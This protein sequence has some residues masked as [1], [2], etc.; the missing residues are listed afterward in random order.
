MVTENFKQLSIGSNETIPDKVNACN[1]YSPKKIMS[2]AE[3]IGL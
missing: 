3:I 2:M 1:N